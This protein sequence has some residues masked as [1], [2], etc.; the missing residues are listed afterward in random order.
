MHLL[1]SYFKQWLHN[2]SQWQASRKMSLPEQAPIGRNACTHGQP[3]NITPLVHQ[4]EGQT[5]KNTVSQLVHTIFS[6]ELDVGLRWYDMD[7]SA[8]Q[9]NY[10]RAR[11]QQDSE[12]ESQTW[13]CM[14]LPP[15]DNSTHQKHTTKLELDSYLTAECLHPNAHV[16]RWDLIT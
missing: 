7:S 12:A 10:V 14:Q 9:T 6:L 11:Y 8:D 2:W 1:F 5:H 4:L 16:C 15:S 3:K 13:W